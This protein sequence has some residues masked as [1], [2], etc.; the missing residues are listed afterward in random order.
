M[1]HQLIPVAWETP[2]RGGR[3]WGGDKERLDSLSWANRMPHEFASWLR[4][5]RS[6]YLTRRLAE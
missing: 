6:S 4:E 5:E 3:G 1:N 2:A